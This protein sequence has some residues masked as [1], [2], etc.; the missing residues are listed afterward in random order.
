MRKRIMILIFTLLSLCLTIPF[1]TAQNNNNNINNASLASSPTATTVKIYVIPVA[2]NV[3]TGMAAF[4]KKSI[5]TITEPDSIIVLE[6]DTFGGRVD[7]ALQIVD[8]LLNDPKGRTIAFVDKKAISAGALIALASNDLVM[9]PSTTIGDCAPISFSQ[10]GPKMM[11]EK[12]QS[13]LRAKFRTLAR[14]NNYPPILSESMVTAEIEVLKVEMPDQ[15]IYIDSQAF[16]DYPE[17]DKKKILS[18]K[19]VVKKGEL[20]TMD[21]TEAKALGFSRMTASTIPDMLSQ[22]KITNYELIRLEQTWSENLGRFIGS[23]SPFL[24]MIGL[25]ALYTE[26]KAPG[27]GVPGIIGITCLGLVFGNQFIVGLADQ[28]ELIIIVL[29][30]VLLGFEVLILPGFGIAGIAGFLCIAI[31][32]VLSFQDFVIPDPTLPWQQEILISNISQVIG[33]L[34]FAFIFSLFFM[35]YLFPHLG[36]IVDGPYLSSSLANSHADSVEASSVQAGDAGVALTY[37]R[38]SGKIKIGNDTFDAISQGE[39]IEKDKSV[40]IIEIKGNRVIVA[41]L[42]Q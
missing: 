20:L 22:M 25:A 6:M 16:A 37:L 4:I 2:G 3:E 24:L 38:P 29:G 42:N 30:F 9:R 21:D 14:R 36:K 15:T 7:S 35:R 11:G 31:G 32:M 8:T 39:F 1:A 19:T 33:S 40:T 34:L 41:R 28:T 26:L 5:S 10:D 18:K 13:P 17:A 27:F 23:I 12:F